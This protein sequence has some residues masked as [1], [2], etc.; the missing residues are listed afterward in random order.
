M[1]K[2]ILGVY[3]RAAAQSCILIIG[4]GIAGVGCKPLQQ[5]GVFSPVTV[6]NNQSIGKGNGQAIAPVDAP[7]QPE[8]TRIF[9]LVHTKLE[10]EPIW[11]KKH[12][13]GL[14][15]LVVTPHVGRKQVLELDAVG[16]EINK[17][18]RI[19][20]GV[21]VPLKYEYDTKQLAITLDSVFT[22]GQRCTVQINYIAKPDEGQVRTG[23]S[24]ISSD[25]GLYFINADGK[26]PNRPRELW[27]QGEPNDNSHWFPT[28]DAPNQK[29]TQEIH[30][31]VDTNFTTLSN[32]LLTAQTL[33][34]GGKRKD[35]WE[36]K[37]PHAPYLFMIAVG[38][39]AIVKDRWRDKEVSYYVEKPH[40]NR[41]KAVFGN[42]P[43]MLEFFSKRLG[44]GFPWPKYSQIV[45]R[46]YVSGAMENTSATLFLEEVMEDDPA[47]RDNNW[48][49]VISHELFHQWFGDLVTTESW[50]NLSLNESFANYGEYLW[51]QY[52][53]GQD[54]ADFHASD[55][56]NQYF[57]ES[58]YKREPLIRYRY[59]S[60][61]DVFD[62]HTYAKGGRILHML[63]NH[64][65]DEVFFASL[66]AYLQK[67]AYKKAEVH[68]LR[69]V[70]EEVSGQ[71]LNWFFNQWYFK[72]GHP[73]L[74]VRK[75]FTGESLIVSVSQMQD[76]TFTP[77]YTLPITID[78]YQGDKRSRH[79]FMLEG[80]D[81]SFEIP[82][83]KAP[84]LTLF[85]PEHVLLAEISFDQT[86]D[87]FVS[88]LNMAPKAID[89][90]SALEK[91]LK[92]ALPDDMNTYIKR[93]LKDKAYQV[94]LM[95]LELCNNNP[96]IDEGTR[97]NIAELAKFDASS[98]V[99]TDA[100]GLIGNQR[101]EPVAQRISSILDNEKAYHVIA[102]AL[103]Q[104]VIAKG[105]DQDAKLKKFETNPSPTVIKVISELY[106]A[107]GTEADLVWFKSRMFDISKNV[108]YLVVKSM[109]TFAGKT[110]G[111]LRADAM[112]VLETLLP[113]Q[114]ESPTLRAALFTA[115]KDMDQKDP[116]TATFKSKLLK[117]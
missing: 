75:T 100:V 65:T 73:E 55:E 12:L 14:A 57:F 50:S 2:S 36:L 7:L 69:L 93:G 68:D 17:V 83:T 20:E 115:S 33:L 113:Y 97:L 116:A 87:E 44:V 40:R 34:P 19:S 18:S 81:G 49:G 30:L 35:I 22:A 95:A 16:F 72:P 10:L 15:T 85:D 1:Q 63:R 28:I 48:D 6:T 89:R 4:M 13:K 103:N 61:L 41:A 38:P 99:R 98:Q 102:E 31:L 78:T 94:R 8:R 70:F 29:T 84:T 26:L 82:M 86:Q 79:T 5:I 32:G 67:F 42:T 59:N 52:K 77:V 27:T 108:Q 91:S 21:L 112:A 104:Y 76:T 47:F 110:K 114:Q 51:W 106:A 3:K 53:R 117:K 11:A 96:D 25:K 37:L 71:D 74:K 80:V 60:Q 109:G 58:R 62:S 39:F 56:K 43:E 105:P 24:A 101:I 23:L 88:A 92:N 64:L 46:D 54:Y 107:R 111:Q 45:G 9:N 66:Q 90:A